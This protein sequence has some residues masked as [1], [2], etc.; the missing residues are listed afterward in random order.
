MA[1]VLIV[2]DEEN[3]RIA[4]R[5]ILEGDGHEVHTAED[6]SDA[7]RL[8]LE[9]DFDVVV[10]DIIMPGFKGTDLLKTIHEKHEGVQVIMITGEP[11][12]DTASEA[13]R[14]GAYD[15]LSKP[16]TGEA[17]KKV[18]ANAAG[19]KALNDEKEWL[20]KEN[21]KYQE[22]L[23]LLVEERTAALNEALLGIVN[24]MSATVEK[25]DLYTAGHQVRVAK[26]ARA[27]AQEMKLPKETIEGTY[28]AG[29]IHD[30]GKISVPAEILAKPSTLL[31]EEFSLIKRHPQ[32]GYDIL[33]TIK[34][35]YPIPKIVMQHHE[36]MDGSGYPQGLTGDDILIEARILAVA[37]T[38]EAMASHR[39]YR[40]SLGVE[41]ALEEIVQK[42]GVLYDENVVG[43]CVG[44]FQT[45]GFEF[46]SQ[47]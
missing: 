29:I 33:K 22:R 10:T 34:F 6:V 43:A 32:T 16:V 46:Q 40:P 13:V 8:M 27:I 24:A 9:H 25:R 7:N 4:F 17:L 19:V 30:I 39:P 23:E 20:T 42:K 3:V 21:Q 47:D 36:R 5:D 45:K 26:L 1:R 15:Y 44:L 14:A 2:D 31:E 35:L 11:T 38:V 41:K 18:V 28:L 12:V 37:D